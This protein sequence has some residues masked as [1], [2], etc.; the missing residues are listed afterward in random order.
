MNVV[1]L[2]AGAVGSLFGA[3]IARAGHS[4][5]LIGRAE[6]VAAVRE[7]GLRVRDG[8]EEVVRLRAETRLAPGLPADVVLVTVK[9]FDLA[10]AM[11]ELAAALPTPVPTLMPQNG[12]GIERRAVAALHEGGWSEAGAWTVRAIHSVPVTW[13]A[14]GVV[15]EAGT[16]EILLAEPSAG[17][18]RTERIELFDRLLRSAGF[19]VRRSAEFEREVWR[20]LLVNATINPLTAVR[21]IPNGALLE[22]EMHREALC[23]L[24]EARQ[25]ASLAGFVFT[26]AETVRE[27]ER[28]ARATAENRSSMLQDMDRG[29]PTEIDAI[30]GELLRVAAAH[31]LPLPATRAIVDEVERRSPRAARP[32]KP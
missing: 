30:S 26:E 13:L 10:S 14:P 8:R 23:L 32:P 31:G 27:F 15:R 17:E 6:H 12:V 20:K 4:V 29:R 1:V 18:P 24:A 16:G 2:G 11:R 25:A 28:V 5:T 22:G 3:R 21:G 7:R 9:S 19:R